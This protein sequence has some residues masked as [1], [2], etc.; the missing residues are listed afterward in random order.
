M[1]CVAQVI[2][3]DMDARRQPLGVVKEQDFG[4][5]LPPGR[6]GMAGVGEVHGF[7]KGDQGTR[8]GDVGI[9]SNLN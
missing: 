9:V 1:A 8:D 2:G 6:V 4:H 7:A 3:E 5:G